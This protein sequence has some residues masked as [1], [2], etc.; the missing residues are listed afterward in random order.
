MNNDDIQPI[1]ELAERFQAARKGLEVALSELDSVDIESDAR[2]ILREGYEVLMQEARNYA[3][4]TD[5]LSGEL[6]AEDELE[7]SQE[8]K[9]A[10][11]DEERNQ[12]YAQEEG[13]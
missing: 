13:T 10:A 8:A 12:Q 4:E 3:A 1:D 11:E 5:Q 7:A 2:R 9:W 6:S